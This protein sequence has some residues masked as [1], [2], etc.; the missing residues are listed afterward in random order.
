MQYHKSE[1]VCLVC[2]ECYEKVY[3]ISEINAKANLKI[4]K[5]LSKIHKK[6]KN[7]INISSGSLIKAGN[8]IAGD[9]T[10]NEENK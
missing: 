4:H 3:G 1:K 9:V 2:P 6:I 5:K 10:T 7:A 8:G